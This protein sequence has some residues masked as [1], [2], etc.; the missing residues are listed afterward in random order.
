MAVAVPKRKHG[1]V[2]LVAFDRTGTVCVKKFK[3]V[4]YLG[5]LLLR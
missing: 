2:E 4:L 5:L 3:D 1:V